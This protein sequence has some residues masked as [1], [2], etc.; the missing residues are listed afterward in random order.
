MY[1]TSRS[2]VLINHRIPPIL[3]SRPIQAAP[4]SPWCDWYLALIL[5]HV[6]VTFVYANVQRIFTSGGRLCV[7]DSA[8]LEAHKEN[9]DGGHKMFMLG[10]GG[11]RDMMVDYLQTFVFS[12]ADICGCL[13]CALIFR[14][15]FIAQLS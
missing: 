5:L 2:L 6:G 9:P 12:A 4:S 10:E 15:L 1:R 13:G 8:I 11:G 3:S 7:D 14:S